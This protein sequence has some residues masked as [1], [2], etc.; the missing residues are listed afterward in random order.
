MTKRR[1]VFWLS[2]FDGAEVVSTLNLTEKS[3]RQILSG[4]PTKTI[5]FC[6][7]PSM[8]SALYNL[9]RQKTD[10]LTGQTL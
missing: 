9:R 8:L 7:S 4:M 3:Q 5:H 1:V 2:L 6:R 10:H